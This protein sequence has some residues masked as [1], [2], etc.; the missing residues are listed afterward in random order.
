MPMRTREIIPSLWSG[1]EMSR[2]EAPKK[3][4]DAARRKWGG[5]R[6]SRQGLVVAATRMTGR[7]VQLRRDTM[8]GSVR[9]LLVVAALLPVPVWAG[10]NWPMYGFD[11]SQSRF[12]RDEKGIDASNAASLQ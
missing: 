9:L 3:T 2:S 6:W 12:N 10:S 1:G 4:K 5:S 8:K 7:S 11:V